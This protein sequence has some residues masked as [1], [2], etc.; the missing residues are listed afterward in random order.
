MKSPWKIAVLLLMLVTGCSVTKTSTEYDDVYSG[1][2]PQ[3]EESSDIVSGSNTT[4][5]DYSEQSKSV[6]YYAED[7]E[8]SEEPAAED[9]PYLTAQE[10]VNSPEGTSYITNNYYGGGYG[11][12]YD[13][14]YA[15][16]LNR[17][18]GPYMGYNY[19][20]PCYSGFYYDPWY[21]DYY[22]YR[23]SLYFGFN[24]GWGDMYWGYP[25]YSYYYPYNSYWS[26]YYNGFWDGYYYGQWG[27]D[28]YG[29]N[30][31]YYGHRPTRSGHN[32]PQFG[33]DK[34]GQ[35]FN[36]VSTQSNY[37]ER[38]KPVVADNFKKPERPSE[39][40]G[41][42]PGRTS[43]NSTNNEPGNRFSESQ[44]VSSQIN[45][46]NNSGTA[47]RTSEVKNTSVQKEPVSGQKY[48]YKK[49]VANESRSAYKPGESIKTSENQQ[50]PVQKYSKPSGYSSSDKA[51]RSNEGSTGANRN[52]QVYSRPQSTQQDSYSKPVKYNIENKS[53]NQ[54]SRSSD[55]YSK[56]SRSVNNNYSQPSRSSESI[57]QPSRSNYNKSYSSPSNSGG[58]R[59]F[60][61]PSRSSN[62]GSYS[63][64]SRSGSSNSGSSSRGGRK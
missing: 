43:N 44:E 20:S 45:K 3:K 14:S 32:S 24:W 22:R 59:N 25:Y 49:P 11:D 39:I 40:G 36:L 1:T 47:D 6:D 13:Y 35:Q 28:Y 61:S 30:N 21:W 19:Y 16:R 51:G 4:S 23:P 62:S 42:V 17:F 50:K 48:V 5:P 9:E 58:N 41:N 63:S 53:Q 64:P 2:S 29:N 27:Y 10:T 52:T 57:S 38:T 26:G 15:S 37:F 56:P 31:Y 54:P 12:Y 60:S 8:S 55:N 46:Q 18:Y 7:F 34:N 33:T